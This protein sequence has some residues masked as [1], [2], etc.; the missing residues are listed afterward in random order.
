M[1]VKS[2]D[3]FLKWFQ[4][5]TP[6]QQQNFRNMTTNDSTIQGY[7]QQY[8]KS[9]TVYTPTTTEK[10]TTVN[11]PTNY[12]WDTGWASNA[13]QYKGTGVASAGSY[14][15]NPNLS[16]SSLQS[17]SL[18]FWGNAE[19]AE[20]RTPWYLEQRNNAI[21]NALY[22][23][24]KSDYN[25]IYN[26]LNTFDDFKHYD[27]VWQDNTVTA[28]MKRMGTMESLANQGKATTADNIGT[29]LQNEIM[30]S[31]YKSKE[32][33][34]NL[35]GW[36][37]NYYDNFW[38]A[39]DGKLKNAYWIEDLNAFKE[40]YPD[41][42]K[43][44]E[45]ALNA[46]EWVW[47]ATDPN[48]R[49]MLDWVLQWIIG[50]GVGYGSDMSKLNVLESSIM[51]KFEDPD[52][53]KQDAQ[54]VIKLQTEWK[55][56]KLIANEMWISED[57][58]QQ[59][60]LLA[61]WLDSKA[62]EYYK[63]K[64]DVAKDITEPYDTKLDRLAEEKKIALD[65]ANRNVEWLKADY[66][67]NYERQVQQNDINAHNMDAIAWR[68]GLGLSKRGI[69]WLNYVNQQAKNILDDLT[70]NYDR[71]SQQMA[72]WIADI[73]RNRQW[74]NDDLMKASEDAL[75]KAKNNFTSNMLAIQQQYWTVGLQAQQYLSQN[76]QSFIEQAEN[77]YDNA[78]TRQQNN[79]T[80][81]I[82]NVSNLNA[83]ALNNLALREA[84]I[85]Q[86][87]NE[88]LNMNRSQ[89]QNLANQLG[90]DSAS[91]GDLVQYQAQA[92]ANELNGYVPG[93]GVMFQEAIQSGLDQWYTPQEVLS[94]IVNSDEFKQATATNSN[95]NWSMSG[96]YL[97]NKAN[98]QY[99]DLN[100]NKANNE[101]A[102][103]WSG[104]IYNKATGELKTKDWKIVTTTNANWTYQQV[105]LWEDIEDTGIASVYQNKDWS[106]VNV[107]LAP[108]VWAML[109]EAYQVLKA[110]WIE[111][112]I[113]DSY[114]TYAQQKQA[115]EADQKLPPAQ[116]KW[117]ANPDKSFHVIW[118]AFDLA[119]TDEMKNNK[120]VHQALLD[121]GFTRP[122]ASERR[123]WSYWEWKDRFWGTPS[124]SS[125]GDS[126]LDNI[127]RHGIKYDTSKYPWR[128]D[129]TDD[130]KLVVQWLLTYQIDPS[131]LPKTW[132]NGESNKKV[133][134]AASYIGKDHWYSESKFKQV[135]AVQKQRDKSAWPGW[136]SSSNSTAASILK[137]VADSFKELKNYDIQAVNSWINQFK[138][139]VWDPTVW[140]MYTD[141]RVASSE[142]AKA[143]KGNASATTDEINQIN[144]LLSWKMST[145]QA[146]AVFKHFAK[147]LVEKNASEAKN[148]YRVVWYKPD[149][150]YLDEVNDWMMSLWVDIPAY[151]NYTPKGWT[152]WGSSVF[153][154][155]WIKIRG[156]R[157]Q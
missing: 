66:D 137:T 25:S 9:N 150:I 87:Q 82:N 81:L 95:D 132:N 92:V 20:N 135:D 107:K 129:L 139:A 118:Q 46:V 125:S 155:T 60:I 56:T 97:Y 76:V 128:Q 40:R 30:D 53:I 145:E 6:S 35:M 49:Q 99:V 24:W 105:K 52:K 31:Y 28:I 123:H 54:K 127:E 86:F 79:L 154:S 3:E 119:Q 75:T 88:S 148:Y 10:A 23:E 114:R 91:Y 84:T 59:L 126:S 140:A 142:I 94:N 72:D 73:I 124:T 62:G 41:Q 1:A 22:N 16:T 152:G 85:K 117:V 90:M 149:S 69:E 70:K 61:N 157:T 106:Y 48:S 51:N 67:T 98:W 134:A 15:Y 115:Y 156:W 12:Y 14:N 27:K 138:Q 143:L 100:T 93:A 96:W 58:V 146:E 5:L 133:R 64:D 130:E 44:L 109:N 136:V 57:Q 45:Q 101:W 43:S 50:T 37:E 33:Y 147:N 116:R 2:Y 38:D 112:Q 141:L 122:V 42:Y 120:A 80:N 7:L 103:A 19:L 36:W 78:L 13:Q 32:W 113:A 39:V 71:N 131:S 121:A 102:S 108:T 47:N 8:D 29:M 17:W 110:Q 74:N 11:Q 77:I 89:L 55:N 4:G 26:Y 65:R 153:T 21:A 18:K 104:I 144:D 68:T 34:S 63:L 83:L 151:Y 111:L